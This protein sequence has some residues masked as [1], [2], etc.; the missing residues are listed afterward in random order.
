MHRATCIFN[1]LIASSVK[2]SLHAL[3][4]WC[5]CV[6]LWRA[7]VACL[8]RHAEAE[9]GLLARHLQACH[10]DHGESDWHVHFAYLNDVLRG[11]GCPV[12]LGDDENDTTSEQMT[13]PVVLLG[14]ARIHFA[15]TG[16]AVAVPSVALPPCPLLIGPR[17][18]V[19]WR[20]QFLS[21]FQ[22]EHRLQAL[23]CSAQC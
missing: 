8:H 15:E 20:R 16:V 21:H 12:P 4:L 7:P 19:H 14:Q 17:L 11:G 5:A 13:A 1:H 6:S 10:N 9:P 3:V 2:A 18:D 23:L 22:M